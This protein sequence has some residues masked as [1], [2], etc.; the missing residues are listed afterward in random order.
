MH[1]P[2][3]ITIE[4]GFTLPFSPAVLPPRLVARLDGAIASIGGA[5]VGLGVFAA[6]LAR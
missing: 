6:Y 5:L 1:P 4:P 2:R 3:I